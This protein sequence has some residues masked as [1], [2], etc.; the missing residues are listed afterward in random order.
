MIP[1]D[2][3]FDPEELSAEQ[4]AAAVADTLGVGGRGGGAEPQVERGT[5]P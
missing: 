1:A 3:V 4:I 2:M 5:H